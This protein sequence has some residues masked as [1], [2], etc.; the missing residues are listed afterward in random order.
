MSE[1]RRIAFVQACWHQDLVDQIKKGFAGEIAQLGVPV[2]HV[3][4]FEVSGAFEI[5]L[6]ARRLAETGTYDAIVA[7]GLVVDGGIYRHEFVAEAVIGGLMQV[8]LETGVP[9][10]SA[11]LTP[12]HFHEHETHRS[13]FFDHLEKKGI[14]AARAC[15][16][17]VGA[18]ERLALGRD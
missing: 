11:V 8:Q 17:T 9:V 15:A 13:F 1:K 3:D 5:P 2:E 16:H 12:H 18:L 6:H 7:A 10:I 14:E 4:Y